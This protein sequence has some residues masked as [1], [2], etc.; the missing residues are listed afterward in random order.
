M[1]LFKLKSPGSLNKKIQILQIF[2][3]N[4]LVNIKGC[5]QPPSLGMRCIFMISI[6]IRHK[7][8]KE[9]SLQNLGMIFIGCMIC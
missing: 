6:Y 1:S 5:I 8:T 3:T 7:K 2:L 4:I 9:D